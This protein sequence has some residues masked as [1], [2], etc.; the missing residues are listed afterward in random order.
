MRITGN[1][2]DEQ[3]QTMMGV[4]VCLAY[5]NGTT[6]QESGKLVCA[7]TDK[8]GKYTIETPLANEDFDPLTFYVR[9]TSVGYST[10]TMEIGDWTSDAMGT[11]NHNITMKKSD[12]VLDAVTVNVSK[13][14]G[15]TARKPNW[16]KIS[17][18]TGSGL[19]LAA[20]AYAIFR[21]LK[22]KK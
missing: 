14:D 17:I 18:Y 21:N 13:P 9:A 8:N 20:I 5:F 10:Y 15:S 7:T 11:L 19:A 1:I 3:G 22:A 6:V 4:N 12:N 16:K 2:K